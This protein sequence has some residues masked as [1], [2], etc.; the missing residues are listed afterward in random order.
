MVLTFTHDELALVK[1]VLETEGYEEDLKQWILD[2]MLTDEEGEPSRYAGAA[3]RVIENVSQ[4][5]QENPN[6]IRAAG[7]LA[8]GILKRVIKKGPPR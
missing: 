3:D 8:N 4:F 6:T 5:V 1:E 2:N 7:A